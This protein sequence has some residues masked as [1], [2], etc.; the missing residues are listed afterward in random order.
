MSLSGT[1][2][3]AKNLGATTTDVIVNGITFGAANS[4]AQYTSPGGTFVNASNYTGPT[5][6]G[7]TAAETTSLL[8]S[9]EFGSGVGNST[10][11]LT[12]LSIGTDYMVQILLS[13]MR[14]SQTWNIGYAETVGGAEVYTPNLIANAGSTGGAQIITGT[15]TATQASQEL[16]FDQNPTNNN[17]EL[18]ALQ[19]RVI[20]EPST[21]LLGGFGLLALLRRRRH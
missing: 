21:A 7:L 11:T 4:V 5:I 10:I 12:G 3:E 17:A 9:V 2:V 16:H 14:S 1:L 19:L 6:T 20:P 8:D 15:F 13:D 18:N